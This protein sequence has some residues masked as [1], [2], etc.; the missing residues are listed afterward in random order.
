VPRIRSL[1]ALAAVLAAALCSAAFSPSA[2][3]GAAAAGDPSASKPG[4]REGRTSKRWTPVGTLPK[5]D[6]AAA[7]LVMHRPESRPENAAVNAYVPTDAEIKA[8]RRATNRWG[9]TNLRV[10]PLTRYVTGRSRLQNPSTDDLIQ[11]TAHKWGIPENW[12]R[13]QMALE[14]WWRQPALGDPTSVGAAWHP[15]Y[16]SRARIAG[17]TN[18]MQSMGLMQVKW[19]PDGSVGAGTEPLRWKSAAFNLDYYGAV[20]RYYYDGHCGWCTSG[21][22]AGQA[23]NSVGAWFAPHPWANADAQGYVR[24]VQH[25]VRARV[26][27]QAGF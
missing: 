14:S 24:R 20:T 25:Y 18:V 22:R 9:Q 13:A 8:Y 21:Y 15:L 11:W 7:A 10:S 5:S 2:P 1:P 4:V 19:M 23:W 26:W 12:I 3:A 6:A 17:T 16:P 27:A